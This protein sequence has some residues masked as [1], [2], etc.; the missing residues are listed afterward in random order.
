MKNGD[1]KKSRI[2]IARAVLI[3]QDTGNIQGLE[4]VH[5]KN[6]EMKKQLSKVWKSGVVNYIR[7]HWCSYISKQS[8]AWR[9]RVVLRD[10]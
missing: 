3:K 2:E 5:M 9:A 7:M 10:F 6:N 8:W 1:N 4:L